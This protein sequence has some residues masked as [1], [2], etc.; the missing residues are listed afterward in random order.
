MCWSVCFVRHI[1]PYRQFGRLAASTIP[2]PI[3]VVRLRDEMI[4]FYR[5]ALVAISNRDGGFE[6]ARMD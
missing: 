1:D 6:I 4:T 3:A 5:H 2:F